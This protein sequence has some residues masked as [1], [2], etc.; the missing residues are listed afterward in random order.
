MK[1]RA[2]VRL[3]GQGPQRCWPFWFC[4]AAGEEPTV[5]FRNL[6]RGLRIVPSRAKRQIGY[7][8]EQEPFGRTDVV[9]G[10]PAIVALVVAALGVLAM[11]IVDHGPWTR[12]KVQT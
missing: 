6:S 1:N 5:R 12:P 11:L 4:I 9:D 2:G 10:P 8:D 3:L 7:P